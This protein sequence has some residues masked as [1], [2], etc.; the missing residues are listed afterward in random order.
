MPITTKIKNK[1]GILLSLEGVISDSDA[2]VLANYFV[3]NLNKTITLDMKEVR[4]LDILTTHM[5]R[6]ANSIV[7]K[8]GGRVIIV[9]IPEEVADKPFMR[10]FTC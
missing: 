10:M 5:L 9:N 8:Y 4:S 6:A 1:D 3:G 2:P 7:K